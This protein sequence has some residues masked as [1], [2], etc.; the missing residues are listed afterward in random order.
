MPRFFNRMITE[1]LSPKDERDPIEVSYQLLLMVRELHQMGYERL[2][3][4]P[5]MSLCGCRW[6]C[7]VTPVVNIRKDHGALLVNFTRNGDML[8][9][10]SIPSPVA[11]YSGPGCRQ[12]FGWQDAAHDS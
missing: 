8:V 7:F 5:G 6:R 4:A 12:Y 9:E 3:I 10:P 2:R 1:V 11:F